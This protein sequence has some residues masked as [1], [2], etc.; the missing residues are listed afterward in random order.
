MQYYE[1]F[2]YCRLYRLADVRNQPE[3]K[4]RRKLWKIQDLPNS[5]H[6][7]AHAQRGWSEAARN[8]AFTWKQLKHVET[9][10]ARADTRNLYIN[11]NNNNE[12]ARSKVCLWACAVMQT[13]GNP[14]NYHN[15]ACA[16]AKFAQSSSDRANLASP[17]F[18]SGSNCYFK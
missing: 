11:N 17:V 1:Q 16:N 18:N 14:I 5:H 7:S 10:Q 2:E 3:S 12:A 15:C 6:R 8:M 9:A 4:L 13:F